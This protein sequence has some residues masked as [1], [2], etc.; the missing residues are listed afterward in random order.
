VKL[1]LKVSVIVVGMAIMATLIYFFVSGILLIAVQALLMAALCGIMIGALIQGEKQGMPSEK[2]WL[3]FSVF[4]GIFLLV[5]AV[6]KLVLFP[7][8][9]IFVW[10]W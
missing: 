3:Y 4:M 9:A 8:S 7:E 2:R 6:V 10:S 1:F 5:Y